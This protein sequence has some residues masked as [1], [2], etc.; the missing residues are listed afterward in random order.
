[1]RNAI[2]IRQRDITDCGAACLASVAAHH[3]LLLPVARIRQFATTDQRGTNMLGMVKAATKLGFQ[4]KGVKGT[5]E[6]LSK[7]PLPAV[8][9][10]VV[11]EQ[12]LHHYVVLYGVTKKRVTYMDPGDGQLHRVPVA[13]FQAQWTGV[14]LL[15]LPNESFVPGNHKSSVL[16]RFWQL[17]Q[18][19]RSVMVQALFGA[20]VYTV[21]GLAMS[22]YVQKIVDHVL[23]DGNR[24]LLNLLSVGMLV[25]LVFQVFIGAMKSLFALQTGQQIDA[26]L[27]LGYYKHLLQLPQTFFDSMRVG[28]IISRVNDAVKIRAFVNDVALNLLVN[29]FIVLLSFAL[30]FTYYWKLAVMMLAILPLYGAI[31]WVQN[32]LNR[33]Y[34]RQLMEQSAELEAQLVESVTAMGTIKRFGMESFALERTETRFIKLLQTVYHSGKQG[35]IGG[36]AS[37]FVSQLFRIGLL[38]VGS[39]FVLDNELTPGELLSFYAVLGYFTGPATSLIGANKT[40]QDAL[41]AADRLFEII[42]LEREAHEN[43]TEL[44]PELAGDIGLHD[45]SFAYNTRGTVFQNLTLHIPR[46]TITGIVGESGSGKTTLLSLLQGL[47]PLTGGRITIGDLDIRH[48]STESLRRVVSVVPQQID[49]FTGSITENIAIGE[50]EPDMR[51]VIGICQQLGI[52]EFVEKLPNGFATTLGERGAGLSGGQKQRLAIARALYRNP[53]IL[54]LDEATSALD[55]VSEQYV[56]GTLRQLRAAGKTVILIAHR[57]STV[58]H[59]DHIMV[60]AAGKLVEQGTHADLLRQMGAYHTLWQQLMPAAP[61]SPPQAHAVAALN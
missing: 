55:T 42:D 33:R 59:A 4:A 27:I 6:S 7:I 34:Q 24:N 23:A 14:L 45:V 49:L 30:M 47:Y 48:L 18:P 44:T 15:L 28:E 17:V 56:Q 25:L 32:R 53:E 1:M 13:E 16:G 29:V 61:A 22:I 38:W 57:L 60:L 20:A 54:I 11:Q 2:K 37:E 46:G 26:R 10:V 43:K 19:H 8:A 9:H 36:S 12:Q 39:Y 3:Q 58:M 41:I 31:Y 21:L 51:R 35:I 40:V 52:L 50:A 5:V